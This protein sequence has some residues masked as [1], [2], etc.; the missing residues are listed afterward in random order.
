[1]SKDICFLGEVNRSLSK[2]LLYD[3]S[4]DYLEDDSGLIINTEKGLVIFTGCGHSGI[5]EIIKKG[6][7]IY[8]NDKVYALI[9]GFH[10]KKISDFESGLLETLRKIPIIYTGHCTKDHV[11]EYLKEQDLPIHTLKTKMRIEI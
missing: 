5:L 3:H 7:E 4:I 1:M 2:H 11:I 9:G 8:L 10:L 6:K